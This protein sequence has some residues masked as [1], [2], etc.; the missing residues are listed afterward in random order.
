MST[1][2]NATH[3]DNDRVQSMFTQFLFLLVLIGSRRSIFCCG[4][5]SMQ[6]QHL[7]QSCSQSFR[8]LNYILPNFKCLINLT[9]RNGK[10]PTPKKSSLLLHVGAYMHA[11]RANTVCKHTLCGGGSECTQ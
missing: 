6:Q 11:Q 2:S 10:Q 9:K 8:S 7:I 3:N 5:T 4:Y 1:Q